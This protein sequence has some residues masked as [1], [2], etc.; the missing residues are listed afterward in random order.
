MTNRLTAGINSKGVF[1]MFA[2][3]VFLYNLVFPFLFLLYLP[4]FVFKL[5]KRGGVDGRYPERFAIFTAAQKAALAGLRR[6]VWVHAVSVGETVAAL[7][8]IRRWRERRPELMFVL[9]SSTTT[10][11]EIAR[12]KAPAGVVVIYCPL[13]W[14]PWVRRTVDLVKPAM[15]VIFEV[16]IWP[17]LLVQARRHGPVVLANGRMSDRS[18]ASYARHAW[19]F[20]PL[21]SRFSALCVQDE[22]DARRFLKAAG[23]GAPI[24]VC[25]TMK[26]DQVP[27]VQTKDLKQVLDQFF[28]FG[29]RRCWVAGST[30]AGEEKMVLDIFANLRRRFPD[31]KLI[32]VPRHAERSPEVVRLLEQMEIRFR[33]LKEPAPGIGTADVLL[34]NTTGELMN[35]YAAADVVY[36]GKTLAGNS[37]GHNIIEPAIFGKPIIH[38]ENMQN[39]RMVADIFKKARATIEVRDADGLAMA[40]F[41]ILSDRDLAVTLVSRSRQVVEDQRGSIDRTID[42]Y[43]PLLPP[44]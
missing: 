16:E 43:T 24:H 3:T 17:N 29:R 10:G 39:F 22:E 23:E 11:Q 30:H 20:R 31:L 37:G 12:K 4:L 35:F 36:V 9:S 27:D 44:A 34:V 6:P 1:L 7:T 28:G 40:V 15:L 38:G 19:F 26:F 18:S 14:W 21:M 8:F 5:W 13:D 42:L 41:E 32:L 25:N 2:F 33:L